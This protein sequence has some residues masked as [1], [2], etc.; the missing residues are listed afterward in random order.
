MPSGT[1]SQILFTSTWDVLMLPPRTMLLQ[2]GVM[3]STQHRSTNTTAN[4]TSCDFSCL[5]TATVLQ[6]I[7]CYCASAKNPMTGYGRHVTL[8]NSAFLVGA[9]PSDAAARRGL[10]AGVVAAASGAAFDDDGAPALLQH[11]CTHAALSRVFE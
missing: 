5:T 10:R 7:H 11:T 8:P 4:T 1:L 6:Q 2:Q 3:P 9:S